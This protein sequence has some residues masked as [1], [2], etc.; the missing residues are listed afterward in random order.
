MRGRTCWTC[1]AVLSILATTA[2]AQEFTIKFKHSS[3]AGQSVTVKENSKET[4]AFTATDPNGKI[5]NQ[6]K[7]TAVIDEAYTETVLEKGDKKPRKFKRTYEKATRSD[8][9]NK[10]TLPYEGRTIVFEMKGD[11]YTATAE[12][13][14][15][16]PKELL[17]E[18]VKRASGNDSEVD[19]A[20]LPQKPVKVG[21]KWAIEPKQVAKALAKEGGLDIDIDKSKGDVTLTKAY[22]KDGAQFGVLEVSMKLAVKKVG[23]L[24]FDPPGTMELKATLDVTIDGTGTAGTETSTSKLQGKGTEMP[25]G[26]QKI[27][28]DLT[29]DGTGKK[30][31]SAQKPAAEK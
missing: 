9:S 6:G 10:L 27:T 23:D 15:A 20:I 25:P 2:R 5:V 26:G 14:P 18:L 16:L 13:T 12:G 30:E 3:D 1:I 29:V 19:D 21:D 8:G 4:T 24:T 28:V 11:K 17:D 7:N 31:V 22:T